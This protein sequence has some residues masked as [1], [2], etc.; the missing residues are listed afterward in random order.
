[1][2]LVGGAT[3]SF[4]LVSW[5]TEPLRPLWDS[6]DAAV[7]Y[8]LNGTLE[9][10]DAW[11]WFWAAANTRIVDACSAALFGA[12]F[13][14]YLFRSGWNG[15]LLR[16]SQGCFLAAFTIFT[17]DLSSNWIFTFERLS[18]SL[19]LEPVYR[20]VDVITSVKVKDVSGNSFPGDH[21]TAVIMFTVLIWH[22]CGRQYGM[23]A[24]A[25]A[26]LL[27][28][29]R[30]VSGAHWASDLLV[31]SASIALLAMLIAVATP[32]ATLLV[33]VFN[34]LLIFAAKPLVKRG[35]LPPAIVIAPS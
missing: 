2:L 25:L 33:N 21:G 7:F 29:P 19:T 32:L 11:R 17:L 15:L 1:M 5:F 35:W 20:L 23:F 22:F 8:A 13:A 6:L 28:W 14:V 3:A 31:G 9:T 26:S 30:L 18:P 27:I 12:I 34:R 10:G 16:F 24:A 4:V